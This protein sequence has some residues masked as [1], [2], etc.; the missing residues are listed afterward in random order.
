ME[1][2]SYL[3]SNINLIKV[4]NMRVVLQC[5][6][7]EKDLSRVQLAQKT[8][9]S[10]TTI[11]N[12]IS[13]LLEQGI[14]SEIDSSE[15]ETETLRP[16]GRPRTTVNLEPNAR[17]VVGVHIGIG[18]FRVAVANLLDEMLVNRREHF[19]I[20]APA[21]KVMEQIAET[22]EQT[23]EESGMDRSLFLGIGIGASGLVEVATGINLLAPNLNWHDVPLRDYFEKKLH[24]P[25]FVDNN[26]RAMAEGEAYFGIGRGVDS[27][28]FVYGRV[29]VGAGLILRGEPFRGS[30]SGAGEIGH[31]VMLLEGG[32]ACQ[33]GNSGCL[34]T[35]VSESAILRCADVIAKRHPDGILARSMLEDRETAPIERVFAAARQGD[36]E[37]LQMLDE[38][39]YYLGVALSG[40]VN[41]FNP[42]MIILGGIFSSGEEYFL[43][44]V[45]RVTRTMAFGRMGERVRFASTGFGWRAGVLGA[46]ALA[47][48]YFFYQP[49][50][51]KQI[52]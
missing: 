12:L 29:G 44:T 10:K 47:L 50:L 51:Q 30:V 13:E 6:L 8:S 27:L 18:V 41:L 49:E 17:F 15:K 35:L 19:E 31:T 9:L 4:H 2:K 7:Y 42:E 20:K 34:E 28:A 26:V 5:L 37:V 24:L 16:V 36:Q 52:R 32:E 46:A 38:R 40:L 39:A 14:V 48:M 43:E 25:V 1:T 45:K 22:I 23:L 21:S 33:C 11:T 3:G